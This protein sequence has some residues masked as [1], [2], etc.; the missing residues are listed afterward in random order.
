LVLVDLPDLHTREEILAVTLGGNSVHPSVNLTLLA[1]EL[2]GYTGSD[3]KEVCREAVVGVPHERARRLEYGLEAALSTHST[4]SGSTLIDRDSTGADST[5]T[6]TDT[7][8]PPSST[9]P[10]PPSTYEDSDSDL[11]DLNA[12]L[13]PV[14]MS[15]FQAAMR[16]LKASVDDNGRE[17]QKVNDWNDKYGEFR[18]KRKP[19][20]K[21]SGLG[22]YI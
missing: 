13:R 12:P 1:A 19:A 7:S 4:Y 11:S 20:S 14:T 8:S 21:G 9:S 5:S 16:K 22:M 10:T 18:R 15:D 17:L 3:V 6:S 2:E